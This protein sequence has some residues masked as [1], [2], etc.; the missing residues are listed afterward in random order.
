LSLR[1]PR[2]LSVF[3][4]PDKACS[5]ESRE[6]WRPHLLRFYWCE[7]SVRDQ[8]NQFVQA[9]ASGVKARSLAHSFLLALEIGNHQPPASFEHTSDFSE[10]L[11]L[12]AIGQMMHHNRTEHHIECLIREGKL[13]DHPDLES[14]RHLAPRSFRAGT[15]DLLWRWVN[16]ENTALRA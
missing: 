3:V 13:L 9:A 7:T 16:A 8:G 15:G 10:T 5:W 12:E 11:T 6:S 1:E 2:T 14:D 4:C